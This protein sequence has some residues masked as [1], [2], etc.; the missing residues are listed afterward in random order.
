MS[1]PSVRRAA[2]PLAAVVLAVTAAFG[3]GPTVLAQDAGGPLTIYSGRADT[4]VAPI[5]ERFTEVTGV[6]VSVRYGGLL[7]LGQQR[8]DK[9]RTRAS[10]WPGVGA[11]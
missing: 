5:L 4:L 2:R 3:P 9:V 11:L 6:D 10:N 7:H 1:T 8:A